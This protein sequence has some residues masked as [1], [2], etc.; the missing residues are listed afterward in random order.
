[1]SSVA[2]G[3]PAATIASWLSDQEGLSSQRT[4]PAGWDVLLAGE[5]KRTI[6]AH[7]E[8]G[9]HTL[10]IQSFF[11]RAPDENAEELF[12]YLLRRNLRTYCLRFA[13]HP[14]GDVLLVGVLPV[15]AIS[16]D[17]LDRVMG[18]LLMAADEAF[19]HALR[20]GFAS[21]IEREQAWR[22]AAGL[23]RNPIT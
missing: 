19:E 7:L 14:D 20:T 13:L 22:I 5:R 3:D 17:E 18:Q 1:M 16:D 11:V 10:S 15:A 21:Y 6:P 4:G 9:D 8:L 2:S 12:A 23:G